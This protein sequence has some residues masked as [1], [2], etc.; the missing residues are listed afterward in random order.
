[1]V[2]RLSHAA[3][4]ERW[5]KDVMTALLA[6]M[7]V[8]VQCDDDGDQKLALQVQALRDSASTPRQRRF[9]QRIVRV[10]MEARV[11]AIGGVAQEK[12]ARAVHAQK[13]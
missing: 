6:A 3:R 10:L 5:A 1:M 2:A 11:R 7:V 8:L 4:T 13:N 12:L 9:V